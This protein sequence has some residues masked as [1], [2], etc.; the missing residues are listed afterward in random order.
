[1]RRDLKLSPQMKRRP[2]FGATAWARP[3]A[4][5][6]GLVHVSGAPASVLTSSPPRPLTLR[7]NRNQWVFAEDS[8]L[9][10]PPACSLPR[11]LPQDGVD[12]VLTPPPHSPPSFAHQFSVSASDYSVYSVGL[13][14]ELI[15]SIHVSF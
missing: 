4:C 7:G 14:S 11:T 13:L 1:M 15:A 3:V 9:P 8:R 6:S 5:A 2:T 10:M 12:F